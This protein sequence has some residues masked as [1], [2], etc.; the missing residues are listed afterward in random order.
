[1]DDLRLRLIERLCRL[2]EKQLPRVETLLNELAQPS[3]LSPSPSF[4]PVAIRNDW[5]HAP[6]HRLSE[7]GT[8]I[9]TASTA[10]KEHFFRGNEKLDCLE[11]HLFALAKK[12]SIL[13]KAWSLFSNHYHIV[14]HL[15][16]DGDSL[17]NMIAEL[18]STSATEINRMDSAR[19]RNVWFNYW[20]TQLTYEG[21]YCARLNYVHHNP[22]KHGLVPRATEYPW[23]SASWFERTATAAQVKTIYDVKIDRVKIDDD[24]EPVL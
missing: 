22:V 18:H 19:G 11:Q 4:S 16:V 9:V 17:R 13:L 23:C 24:Y 14:A 5:P 6:V 8:Y 21:S 2:P 12:Y 20:D 10:N 1:M 15:T 7:R 3:T